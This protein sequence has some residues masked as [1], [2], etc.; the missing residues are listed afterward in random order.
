MLRVLLM[1]RG[2]KQRPEVWQREPF[3][4]VG[5]D[6]EVTDTREHVGL[7]T[8]QR[9]LGVVGRRPGLA[10][11]ELPRGVRGATLAAERQGLIEWREGWYLTLK[12][13]EVR[14]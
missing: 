7:V 1:S 6:D 5:G 2:R 12:G 8:M 14:L 9:L 11:L 13:A 3:A 10:G 4:W